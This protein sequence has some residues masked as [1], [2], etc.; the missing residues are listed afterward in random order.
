MRSDAVKSGIER[1]PHRAILKCLGV[2]DEDFDKPFIGIANSYT[3][4]VPGHMHLDK[5]VEFVKAGIRAAGGVPFEFN[6]IAICDGLA[7]GHEGMHYSLPSRELIAD[8]IE[9]MVQAHRFDGLVLL[10]NCDKIT[11]GMVMAAARIDIPSIVVTGGPMLSGIFKGRKVD[12]TAVFEAVGAVI[13]GKLSAEDL[14]EIEE[15]AFPGC[16]SCNGMY[17]ANTMACITESLGLSLPRCATSLAVSSLKAR[18][19]KKSGQRIVEMVK[20][21]LR[22]SKVLTREAFENAITVDMALGGSTNAVLHLKA[23]AEE[24]GVDLPLKIFDEISKK[25]PHL[26]DMR[27]S[28]PHD[29]EE[30]D[31]AGGLPALMS[32]LKNKL[33]LNALTVTGKTVGENIK[34]AVVYD[35]EVIRP[36]EKPIHK[37]GGIAV[38]TGNLAPDGAVTK[39][40]A[41]SPKMLVYRGPARVFNSEEEAMAAI[42]NREINR[43]EVLVIRY[44]GPKGGPG[45]REMLSPT[46]AIAGMGLSESVALITDGRFSGA[47]VGPC[48]GHVSPEAA[49]GGPIAAV[50][51][52]DIIEIDIP[53]RRLSVDISE[54][55]INKR[56]AEW[57]PRPPKISRGYLARYW[58]MVQSADKGGTFKRPQLG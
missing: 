18:I 37:E 24:S 34:G 56:L 52:G 15:R 14:K 40:T 4:I 51:D 39:V 47:T 31:V 36:L 48:I 43:G 6:T 46:A 26:C 3:E 5:L 8:S 30:L 38:L 19:A 28:G 42:L 44:E 2:T 20:E 1:A 32:R 49:V 9:V 35:S 17:T 10:T 53:R 55:E 23:I 16:G 57:K 50:K 41:I 12:V 27:P 7:M 13:S 45:M 21:D 29:L 25:T 11:P 54:S 58:S 33:H 22:P